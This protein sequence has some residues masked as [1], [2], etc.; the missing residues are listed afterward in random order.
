MNRILIFLCILLFTQCSTN[1]NQNSELTKSETKKIES[2]IQQIK[3][4]NS[5][6]LFIKRTNELQLICSKNSTT[7]L[8]NKLNNPSNYVRKAVIKVLGNLGDARAVTPLIKMLNDTDESIRNETLISLGKLKDKQAIDPILTAFNKGLLDECKVANTLFALNYEKMNDFILHNYNKNNEY[9]C[10]YPELADYATIDEKFT[11]LLLESL[12]YNTCVSAI[13][14][15]GELKV[16]KACNDLIKILD[17]D[18]NYHVKSAAEALGKIGDKRATIPLINLMEK[19]KKAR[20]VAAKSLGLIGDKRAVTSLIALVSLIDDPSIEDRK[21]FGFDRYHLS[22]SG[23]E[24]N[25]AAEAL[26]KIGDRR[27]LKPL[28]K[29]LYHENFYNYSGVSAALDHFNI[30]STLNNDQLIRYYIM[31]KDKEH[32]AQN[33][34]KAKSILKKGLKSTSKMQIFISIGDRNDIPYLIK[35]INSSSNSSIPSLFL[36]CGEPKLVAAAK[37]WA[38]E[39]DYKVIQ[40]DKNYKH[41][42]WGQ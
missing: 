36:N 22:Y 21:K 42:I 12:K 11:D 31:K 19:N 18:Y 14:N 35:C 33:W 20:S 1:K 2:K 41:S 27:A 40:Y 4:S 7:F 16:K 15:L 23:V 38:R 26:G 6:D 5:L 9:L 17:S 39:N 13:E 24:I 28:L 30:V 32:L 37:K 25:N 10:C 8:C 3:E 34:D 29:V